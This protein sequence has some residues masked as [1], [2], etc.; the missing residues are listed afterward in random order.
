MT[1]LSRR[2]LLAGGL[3]MFGGA[4]VAAGGYVLVETGIAPG[5]YRLAQIMGACGNDPGL[6]KVTAGPVLATRFMSRYRR[7]NVEMFVMRPPGRHEVLPVAIVLHGAGDDAASAI[8]LGFPEF[9]AAA[10]AHGGTPPF[11]LVSVDGGGSTYWHPRADGDDPLGMIIHEVLPRLGEQGY[12][13]DRVGL[14]G[15]S[16]GG[17]GALLLAGRL[18]PARVMA[19]AASSPAIFA[20][21]GAAHAAN[22][23]AFDS[24]A[25]FEA[26]S[27]GDVLGTLKLLPVM[28]DCGSSDPFAAQ[29]ALLRHRLGNP[30]GG[31]STGCHDQAFWRRHLPAQLAFL[32]A[33][34]S[35]P[36]A[37]SAG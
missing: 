22:N 20:S 35:H 2:R 10:L 30:P 21:Y 18:G 5:K 29:D 9:L 19:V 24:A 6:P 7:R 12:R 11:A 8:Q 32:G 37:P 27:V 33:H 31:I 25:D 15:W 16:M 36:D 28:I 14:I 17:Y 23:R 13:A 1:F 4:V 34:L 26:N 3:S